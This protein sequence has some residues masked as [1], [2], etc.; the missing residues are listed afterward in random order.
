[1]LHNEIGCFSFVKVALF[2]E[3]FNK[4]RNVE[5]GLKALPFHN[6]PYPHHSASEE[7]PWK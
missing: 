1:L 5:T 7:Q 6:S 4:N 2:V 3:K